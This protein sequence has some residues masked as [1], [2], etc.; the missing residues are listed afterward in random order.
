L[1]DNQ[2]HSEVVKKYE[3]LHLKPKEETVVRSPKGTSSKYSDK[4]CRYYK[5]PSELELNTKKHF[6]Q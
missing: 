1:K 5:G 2:K 3:H 4:Y 6:K